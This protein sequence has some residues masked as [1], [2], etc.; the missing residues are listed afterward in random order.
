MCPRCGTPASEGVWCDSCGLNLRQQ[1]ELPSANAYTARIREQRWLA[2]QAEEADAARADQP[3]REEER[4]A[5]TRGQWEHE[6]QER[7]QLRTATAARKE[8][9]RAKRKTPGRPRRR[10]SLIGL[11]AAL[12]VLL[13]TGGAGVVMWGSRAPESATEPRPAAQR[14]VPDPGPQPRCSRRTAQRELVRRSLLGDGFTGISRLICRDFTNDGAE[15]AAFTRESIGS[16]GTLGW[17][18]LVAKPGGWDL[19][20]LKKDDAQVGIKAA[21]GDLLRSAPIAD[22]A[23]PAYEEGE[24]AVIEAYR[25]KKDHFELVDDRRQFGAAFPDGFYEEPAEEEESLSVEQCGDSEPAPIYNVTAENVDCETALEVA[26]AHT[27]AE[28]L[29]WTCT[30]E[31]TGYESSHYSCLKGDARVTYDF[32]V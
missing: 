9:E 31:D 6:R 18:V 10:K 21:R 22:A 2:A 25:W 11:T 3:P 20:L 17:G 28:D 23:D 8:E 24:G 15:D 7:E 14:P 29:G 26:E 4:R 12:A 13:A 1:T 27:Q 32:S 30:D 5:A 19:P 16:S